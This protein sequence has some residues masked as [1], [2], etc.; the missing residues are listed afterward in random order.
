MPKTL[1]NVQ[2]RISKTQTKILKLAIK[3]FIQT[4]FFSLLPSQSIK[5]DGDIGAQQS[6]STSNCPRDRQESFHQKSG[7]EFVD[8]VQ[9]HFKNITE[10]M[11]VIKRSV[12]GFGEDKDSLDSSDRKPVDDAFP[13]ST[14][15]HAAEKFSEM[16]PL[17]QGQKIKERVER[18]VKLVRSTAQK[19][20]W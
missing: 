1:F 7:T 2:M 18:I 17:Q 11:R 20:S 12:D 16:D 4:A 10:K 13:E 5:A 15:G 6:A 19:V 8:N 9:L 3:V 14:D